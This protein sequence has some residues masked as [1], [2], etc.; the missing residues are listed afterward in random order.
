MGVDAMSELSG[1]WSDIT[2]TGP[3]TSP[4]EYEADT[5]DEFARR[6]RIS[7]AQ[8]YKEVAEG[9]LIA[10]KVGVR[11]LILREHAAAWR[12]A[13]PRMVSP[14]EDSAVGQKRKRETEAPGPEAA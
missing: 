13:L 8:A 1:P 6:H 3:S 7:R 10:S 11:T 14:G 5:I 9:R 12:K 2:P 4:D